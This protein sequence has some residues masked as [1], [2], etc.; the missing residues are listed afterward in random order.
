MT[1]H[2]RPTTDLCDAHPARVHAAEPVF[3]DF[4]GRVAFAGP[5]ATLKV[6]EDN[7]LVRSALETPGNGRVLVVDGGGSKRSA[8]VGGNLGQL[9]VQ[10]GWE[11][12]V[13]F[14]CVRDTAELAAADVA[15]K[16]LAAHPM[17]S[18]KRGAGEKDVAVTF[19][20]VTFEPGAWVYG[21]ADGVIVADGPLP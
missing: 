12:I 9:A 17:K 7:A 16:A 13:V 2:R 19:A 8:L 18:A 3:R 20:G 14:G 11:G 21:D 15:V 5:I 6:F 10:N 4:G 1:T